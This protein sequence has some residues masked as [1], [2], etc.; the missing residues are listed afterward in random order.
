MLQNT[1]LESPEPLPGALGRTEEE[2]LADY[3]THAAG[4]C[5]CARA[6]IWL[7]GVKRSR[8][9]SD[10]LKELQ[11][12]LQPVF[13]GI[14]SVSEAA[15]ATADG[16]RAL[17][18][19]VGLLRYALAALPEAESAL[20]RTVQVRRPQCD[21]A[22]RALVIAESLLASLRYRFSDSAFAAYLQA[23]QGIVVLN[24]SELWAMIPAL[25]LVLLER[26][27]TLAVHPPPGDDLAICL[28]SLREVE[29]AP[30][31]ELLEPLMVFDQVLRQ[32]PAG[33]YPCMD[34][35]SRE[36]YR[37]TVVKLAQFSDY[38]EAEI[39]ET[40]VALA[41]ESRR[42]P[43]PDP[44][45]ATRRSH[46]G[47]YLV[48]EGRE[49]LT[50]RAGV[51]LPVAERCQAFLR[52][53]PDEFYLAGI[54]LLTV[55]MIVAVLWWSDFNSLLGAFFAAAALL[56]PCSQSAVEIMNYLTTSVFVATNSPQARF[57]GRHSGRPHHHGG[58]A[59]AVVECQA[60]AAARRRT[61]DSLCRK[62]ERE[63][64][65]CPADGFGRCGR[66]AAGK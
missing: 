27:A 18:E 21:V 36:M 10:R 65:F 16:Q 43:D 37:Q 39:A 52:R 5:A 11:S 47:Y 2:A 19:N 4:A 3:Q 8:H 41:R 33:A 35:E 12:Q 55:T 6:L 48:A 20:S 7:P 45:M 49:L 9:F 30:W 63:S 40:A 26:I 31:K 58:G 61:G 29:E 46:V 25:K 14:A 56:L 22:P 42:S 54:E 51:H 53:Y 59:N 66:A 50:R 34:A 28:K 24:L 1:S 32:D 17:C 38:S 15:M 44:R 13:A 62:P 23:L 60:G 64:A 57:S